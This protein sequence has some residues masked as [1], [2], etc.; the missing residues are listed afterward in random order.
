MCTLIAWVRHFPSLPLVVAANRDEMLDRPASPPR[1]WSAGP[2]PFVAPRDEKAGG[3]WLGLNQA[4]LFVGVTN[5]FGVPRDDTRASRGRL[6][7]ESLAH[8]SAES[9]HRELGLLP[10]DAFNGFHLLYADRR[11]AFVTWSDGSTLAQQELAPGV[12]VVT[13]R[14]LGGDDRARTELVRERWRPMD[15]A[16]VPRLDRLFELLRLHGKSDPIG[17]TCVHA[18]GAPYGTRSSLLLILAPTWAGTRLFW[19]EGS[20]C[21]AKYADRSELLALLQ[22]TFMV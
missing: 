9:L 21:T 3:T 10:A 1:L 19:A 14:S 2:T 16:P 17:G 8:A 13:E 6:V 22:G 11:R 12:H 20:P 4:G 18:P 5:R 7:V 15:D